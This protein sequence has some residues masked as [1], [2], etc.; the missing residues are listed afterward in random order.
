MST[1]KKN[2][3]QH[4]Q[5]GSPMDQPKG[6]WIIYLEQTNAQVVVIPRTW[7]VCPI[8]QAPRPTAANI[9]AAKLQ[10]AMDNDQ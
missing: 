2:W 3:C 4:I 8:C 7:K 9:K 1:M 6:G 10:F 5:W